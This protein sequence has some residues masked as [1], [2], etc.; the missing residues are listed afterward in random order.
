MIVVPK[1][2][3][4]MMMKLNNKKTLIEVEAVIDEYAWMM[5]LV[6]H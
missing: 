1:S 5:M 3:I 2:M 6:I 4:K